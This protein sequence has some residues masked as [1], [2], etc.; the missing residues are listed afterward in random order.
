MDAA[1]KHMV[2]D[3]YQEAAQEA[4]RRGLS[5]L[6]SHKEG[7]VAAAMLL[8]AITGQEDDEARGAVVGLNLR[9]AYGEEA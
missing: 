6:T 3:I 7:V 4:L 5:R 1:T 8:S 2:E 9:P